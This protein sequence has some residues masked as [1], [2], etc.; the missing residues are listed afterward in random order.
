MGMFGCGWQR[1]EVLTV[2]GEIYK[3]YND[4]LYYVGG[5]LLLTV[6]VCLC[7]FEFYCVE[8]LPLLGVNDAVL[9]IFC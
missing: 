6:S 5:C 4:M 7:F 8:V 2:D 9:L 3:L 1:Q